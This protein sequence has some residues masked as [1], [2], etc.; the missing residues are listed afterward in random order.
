[1]IIMIMITIND[2]YDHADYNYYD[3]DYHDYHDYDYDYDDYHDW[4]DYDGYDYD[5]QDYDDDYNHDHYHELGF[6]P[7]EMIINEP[8]LGILKQNLKENFVRG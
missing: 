1:M 8:L 4:D 5:D 6:V 3:Y 7:L 2:Y